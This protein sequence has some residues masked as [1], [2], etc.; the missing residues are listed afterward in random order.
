L[1]QGVPSVRATSAEELTAALERS[2]ATPGPMFI[3]A[4]LPKRFG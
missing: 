1:A 4:V 3:E 2:Y